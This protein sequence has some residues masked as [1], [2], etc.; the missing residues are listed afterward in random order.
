MK[1]FFTTILILFFTF[2]SR[3][4]AED[5]NTQQLLLNGRELFSSSLDDYQQIEPAIKNFESLENMSNDLAGRA[6]VYIGA[7]Q[8][9]KAK[10]SFWPHK[11]LQ[12]LD[13][14]LTTMAIGIERQ[15]NDIESLFVQGSILYNLPSLF[16]KREQAMDNFNK[17]VKLLPEYHS[18]YNRSFL[19]EMIGYIKTNISITKQQDAILEKILSSDLVAVN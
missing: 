12:L 5:A 8:A 6:Q 19:I 9:L 11:K 7:L 13:E 17:I 14:A 4:S 15:P 10:H 2:S 3:L 16:G 18:H 1:S